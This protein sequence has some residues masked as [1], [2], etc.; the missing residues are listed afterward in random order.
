V[1]LLHDNQQQKILL[2]LL[3]Y[4][5]GQF[6][7]KK[8]FQKIYNQIQTNIADK[9]LYA[10]VIINWKISGNKEDEFRNGAIVPGVISTNTKQVKVAEKTISG[11]SKILSN[12][13]QY[14]TD[15]IFTPVTDINGLD[16]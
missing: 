7:D 2:E 5:F 6:Y 13:L 1:H 12:P 9:K 11:I 14:Y 16:S 10:T 3:Y 4:N 8:Y 15:T